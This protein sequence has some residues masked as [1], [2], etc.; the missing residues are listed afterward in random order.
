MQLPG[1]LVRLRSGL[2]GCL[3]LMLRVAGP[4]TLRVCRFAYET[5]ARA[6]LR[7]RIEPGVQFVGPIHV[8][9]TG[10]VHI[11][12]GTRVGRR[13][14]FETYGDACIEIGRHVT[15]NDGVVIVA[16]AGVRIGDWAMIGEYAGVRD[17][18]HET[19]PGIPVRLQPHD[20]SPV[21][22][23]ADAWIGRSAIILRG[24]AIGPGAIVGANAVVTHDVP[25]GVVV[26][27]V[28]ARNR[29]VRGGA[30]RVRREE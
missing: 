26:M 18:N 10:H 12:A 19:A 4:V 21:N 1:F 25:P 15:I 23:G 14:F 2:A 22:I 28:P 24:T 9:G 8:E 16:Y 27:G 30:E 7:G 20:A 3:G 6:L 5:R 11:G 17:A 13:V 29:S